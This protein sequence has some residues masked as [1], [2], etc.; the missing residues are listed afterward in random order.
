MDI[1]GVIQLISG[2][3]IILFLPGYLFMRL[4][5]KGIKG[6]ELLL[7]T[8]GI[9][10]CI[11]ILIGLFLGV[12]GIFNY[13]NSVIAFIIVIGLITGSYYLKRLL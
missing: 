13:W 10:I 8:M 2:L 11:S 1:L 9:S 4:F 5:Y 12:I 3:M 6:L 7:L